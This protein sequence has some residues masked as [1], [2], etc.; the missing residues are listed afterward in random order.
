MRSKP[1]ALRVFVFAIVCEIFPSPSAI[2]AQETVT[3]HA[4]VTASTG[5]SDGVFTVSRKS[6]AVDLGRKPQEVFGWMPLRG[7]RAGLQLALLIDDSSNFSVPRLNDI[8]KFIEALPPTT[9]IAVGYMQNGRA[10]IA[11]SFTDDH[12]AAAS[13]LWTARSTTGDSTSRYPCLSDLV[14]Y[15]PG[16]KQD[17][18]HE[19]I[20]VTDGM[21]PY[22][23]WAS[24]CADDPHVQATISDAQESNVIVYTINSAGAGRRGVDSLMEKTGQNYLIQVSNATGGKAYFGYPV[25]LAPLLFDIL[26]KLD[27]QYELSFVTATENALE[28]LE[29][30]TT[31][32][33]TRLRA[34]EHIWIKNRE[35]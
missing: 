13:A 19:V 4:I 3:V 20:I 11:Q 18:R 8:E 1:W 34:P 28:S 9:E 6:I 29:V 32:P 17:Q 33:D 26:C 27:N 30:K 25:T 10:N 7:T 35:K 5:L 23:G 2:H 14:K 15:W 12:G 31:E 22:S 21:D 16:G 24:Y